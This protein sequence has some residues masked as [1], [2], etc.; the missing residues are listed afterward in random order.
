MKSRLF[1]FFK[2]AAC[3]SAIA[4]VALLL[5]PKQAAASGALVVPEP[6]MLVLL[7]VGLSAVAMRVRSRRRP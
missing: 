1:K 3:L 6:A 7:G 5:E 2:W 4:G